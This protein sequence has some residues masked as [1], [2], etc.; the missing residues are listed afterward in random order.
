LGESVT[1]FTYQL[2]FKVNKEGS[3]R[4]LIQKQPGIDLRM[5]IRL[6][7]KVVEEFD[8]LTDREIE[9]KR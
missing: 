5:L 4:L 2:P 3:Y 9:I 7:G 8:L 1:E 6:N